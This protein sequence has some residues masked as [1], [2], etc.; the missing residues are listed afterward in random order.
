MSMMKEETI[1]LQVKFLIDHYN[2]CFCGNNNMG[3][4]P[5]RGIIQAD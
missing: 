2:L 4:Y 3:R 1:K 5:G